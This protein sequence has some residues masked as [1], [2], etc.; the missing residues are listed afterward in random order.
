VVTFVSRG[1]ESV[2]GFDIF[3]KAAKKIAQQVPD[4]LFL[5]AGDERTN[6][7]HELHHIGEQSFKQWVLSQDEYDLGKFQFLGLIPPTDLATLYNLSDVHIYLTVPY[8]LSWSLMQGLASGCTVVGS[9]TAPV[10]EVIEDGTHGLLADFYDADG[11]A[12]RA[13]R[14]LRDLEGHR[15]LGAAARALVMEKYERR[16]CAGELAKLFQ[17]LAHRGA[18]DFFASLGGETP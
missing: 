1:L 7:G 16:H 5:V 4:V 9:A 2:R 11:I 8:V 17:S 6:Y 3:M 18:D 15:P 12:E 13:V 14:V 10:Q